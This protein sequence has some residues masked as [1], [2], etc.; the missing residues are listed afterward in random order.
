MPT[1]GVAGFARVTLATIRIV[2]GG[3]ALCAPSVLTRRLGVE[4]GGNQA[5]EYAFRM[6]GIRTILIGIE[7]LLPDGEVRT[8]AVRVAPVIHAT[9]TVS[10]AVAGLTRQLPARS[11]AVATTISAVNTVLALTARAGE[12]AARAEA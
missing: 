11:A 10:A 5:V 2:N 7:L 4:P 9:D 8:A 1:G 12:R 3:T 6:F